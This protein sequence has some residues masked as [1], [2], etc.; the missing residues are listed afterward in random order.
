MEVG[1][2]CQEGLGSRL[3]KERSRQ[4]SRWLELG[5]EDYLV[6]QFLGPE[7]FLTEMSP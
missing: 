6:Q 1:S 7:R 5:Y 2:R 3:Y 4:V